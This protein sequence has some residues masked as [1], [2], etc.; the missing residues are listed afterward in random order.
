MCI[1]IYVYVYVHTHTYAYYILALLRLHPLQA[2]ST[3]ERTRA[4][5]EAEFLQR[6][7]IDCEAQVSL[8]AQDCNKF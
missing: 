4:S 8:L 2:S 3:D 7:Y 1:Y 5:S 6:G